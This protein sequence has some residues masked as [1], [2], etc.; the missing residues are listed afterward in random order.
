MVFGKKSNGKEIPEFVKSLKKLF[1]SGESAYSYASPYM[2]PDGAGSVIMLD[3]IAVYQVMLYFS[4]KYEELQKE[5]SKKQKFYEKIMN[6]MSKRFPGDYYAAF[7]SFEDM[8]TSDRNEMVT[9]LICLISFSALA[10]RF[11]GIE[12]GLDVGNTTD[13]LLPYLS[14]N[15]VIGQVISVDNIELI[16][17][18]TGRFWERRHLGVLKTSVAYSPPSISLNRTYPA[19]FTPPS[20]P[21][22]F[23]SRAEDLFKMAKEFE[24][25]GAL[26]RAEE[27]ISKAEDSKLQELINKK[28]MGQGLTDAE[29]Y[30]QEREKIHE[31]RVSPTRTTAIQEETEE[32]DD[33]KFDFDSRI[34]T[35][36][37]PVF[38]NEIIGNETAKRALKDALIL[39]VKKPNFFPAGFPSKILFYGPPGCGKTLLAAAVT[40]E[41]GG[42]FLEVDTADIM[43]RFVGGGERNVA[44]LFDK[45]RNLAKS[46]KPVIIFMDELDDLLGKQ[47]EHE[48]ATK[49]RNQFQR[50]LDGLKT[51]GKSQLPLFFIGATNKPWQLNEPLIRRFERRVHVEPPDQNDRIELFRMYLGKLRPAYEIDSGVNY[52]ELARMTDR[53]SADDIKNIVKD[54]QY[55]IC[56]DM[57][58]KGLLEKTE[59]PRKITMEDCSKAVTARKTS[60][61]KEDL[62]SQKE[63]QRKYGAE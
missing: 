37:P 7:R 24:K 41:I 9:R 56:Y 11:Q 13:L 34:I 12:T 33:E 14:E 26:A 48:S 38:F 49:V 2:G 59:K 23:Q 43:S 15:K 39:P 30:R 36:L 19:G 5:V 8:H 46:G 54:I 45:G 35:E 27:F 32:E 40:N 1:G 53:Y 51:K 16:N 25:T 63:W 10:K 42:T 52:E 60:I 47:F 29:K 3:I 18:W 57:E 4:D 62:E 58:E 22:T 6:D 55:I 50:E 31:I 44:E 21:P 17:R 20:K 61:T 28:P